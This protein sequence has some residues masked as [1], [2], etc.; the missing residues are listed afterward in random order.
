MEKHGTVLVSI[1]TRRISLKRTNS[2]RYFHSENLTKNRND[3]LA[4]AYFYI[5]T[6]NVQRGSLIG[7]KVIRKI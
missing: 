5:I 2:L 7:W 4:L 1:V 3:R 6:N